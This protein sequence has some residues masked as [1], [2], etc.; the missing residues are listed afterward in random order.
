MGKRRLI[1][2]KKPS[3]QCNENCT[4][5]LLLTICK[6]CNYTSRGSIFYGN[7]T[8]FYYLRMC[9]IPVCHGLHTN[10]GHRILKC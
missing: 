10:L 8:F 5:I 1:P 3:Y 7:K 9:K 2:E 4:C 6:S